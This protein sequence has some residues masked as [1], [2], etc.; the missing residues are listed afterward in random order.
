[1]TRKFMKCS[2]YKNKSINKS[3][4]KVED[5]MLSQKDFK[6]QISLGYVVKPYVKKLKK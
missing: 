3:L 2:I 6:F 5:A 4:K 1:M